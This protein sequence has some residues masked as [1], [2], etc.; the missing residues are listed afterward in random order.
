MVLWL[1]LGMGTAK[2]NKKVYEE[3]ESRMARIKWQEKMITES[4]VAQ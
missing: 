2:Q 3:Y 4:E 1:K